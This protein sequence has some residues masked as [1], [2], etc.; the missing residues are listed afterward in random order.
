[1]ARADWLPTARPN[2]PLSPPDDKD[3][4]EFQELRNEV[5]QC[6]IIRFCRPMMQK[7]AYEL[8]LKDEKKAMHLKCAHFLE[9]NAHRCERCRG[10]DF[11]PFHHFAVDIWLNKLD[12][13]TMKQ[14]VRSY[15]YQCKLSWFRRNCDY[16]RVA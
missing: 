4:E 6:H 13:A 3:R 10:T 11:V 2:S 5:I 12:M 7:T 8:W 14:L 15:G 16:F 1:M 9:E